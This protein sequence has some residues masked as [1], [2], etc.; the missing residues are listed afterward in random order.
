MQ[1]DG[2]AVADYMEAS[3]RSDVSCFASSCYD[4]MS[5]SHELMMM[6]GCLLYPFPP[7]TLVTLGVGPIPIA[8]LLSCVITISAVVIHVC[9]CVL[10]ISCVRVCA[11][12][13]NCLFVCLCVCVCV[14]YPASISVTAPSTRNTRRQ[15]APAAACVLLPPPPCSH[16]FCCPRVAQH[17]GDWGSTAIAAACVC[18]CVCVLACICPLLPSP[19]SFFLLFHPRWCAPLQHV[20]LCAVCLCAHLQARRR[21]QEHVCIK[22]GV[23]G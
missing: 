7:P 8:S 15:A 19:M 12:P 23:L 9:V 16:V 11:L 10:P 5:A 4:D 1:T 13:M 17:G 20:S 3:R 14:Y 2:G 22:C 18:V 6:M 21:Q